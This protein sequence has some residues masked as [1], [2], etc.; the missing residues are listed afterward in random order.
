MATLARDDYGWS[1]GAGSGPSILGIAPAA[2]VFAMSVG[3]H[4]GSDKGGGCS[5]VLT[6]VEL[7]ENSRFGSMWPVL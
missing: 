4:A 7:V 5:R 3:N 1:A 6:F 2:G